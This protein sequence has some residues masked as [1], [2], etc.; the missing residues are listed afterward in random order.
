MI[1]LGLLIRL[2]RDKRGIGAIEFAILAPVLLLLYLGALEITVALS[3]AKR[4]SR[5]SGTIADIVTQQSSVTK[6]FLA[7]MPSAA[8]AIFAPFG[9]TGMTMKITGITIDSS[10]KAT[11]AWSWAQNGTTP[12]SAGSAAS[13]VP[14]DMNTAGSFLVRTELSI[15]Y[16]MLSFGPDFLPSGTN[17]I[18]ISR[19]YF[20]RQRT[21]Q[22][23]PCSDC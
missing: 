20:Y 13:G 5:A 16:Q 2:S 12:Y 21:G 6:S 9:T 1:P 3:V 15:P 8:S 17:T 11:V 22:S 7:T 14:T 18:T 4:T 10:S 19:E 23:I